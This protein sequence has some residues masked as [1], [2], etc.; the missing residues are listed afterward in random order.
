MQEADGLGE[1][2][3]AEASQQIGR[4]G[5][6]EVEARQRL[7]DQPAQRGLTQAGRGRIDRCQHF[8][9][10]LPGSHGME[11][12]VDD[13]GAEV[14]LVHFAENAQPR[15][16]LQHFLLARVEIQKPEGKRAAGIAHTRDQLAP[17][18]VGDLAGNH[19]RP[20]TARRCRAG[21]AA[22]GV[23]RVSSS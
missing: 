19:P 17:R 16:G 7:L 1:T 23:M 13:L 3:Q 9:Q 20:R 10:A 14:A 15:A 6:T 4:Q 21:A 11:A 5:V 22:S 18:P 12:R 2:G 8:R